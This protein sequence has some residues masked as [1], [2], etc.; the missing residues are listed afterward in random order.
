MEADKC[1]KQLQKGSVSV[2]FGHVQKYIIKSIV[3][4]IQSD[5]SDGNNGYREYYG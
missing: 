1:C 5:L 4:G 2:Y 3:L